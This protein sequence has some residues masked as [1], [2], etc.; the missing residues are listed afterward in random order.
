MALVDVGKWEET[1][2]IRDQ[3]ARLRMLGVIANGLEVA[4]REGGKRGMHWEFGVGRYE[5]LHL[6]QTDNKVLQDMRN[7]ISVFYY[8]A[9]LKL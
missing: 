6:E 1:R 8:F 3:Q 5:L 9:F 7:G 4:K 2:D